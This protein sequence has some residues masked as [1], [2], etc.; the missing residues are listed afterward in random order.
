MSLDRQMLR[1]VVP[2]LLALGLVA[3]VTRPLTFDTDQFPGTPS[4]SCN[5]PCPVGVG[6]PGYLPPTSVGGVHLPTATGVVK[7]SGPAAP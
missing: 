6:G 4:R 2:P 5:A 7:E 3:A 1:V